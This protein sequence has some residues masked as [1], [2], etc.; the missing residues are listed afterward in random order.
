M[1]WM[2]RATWQAIVEFVG[3]ATD[4]SKRIGGTKRIRLNYQLLQEL[5]DQRAEMDGKMGIYGRKPI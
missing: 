5:L 3:E 2:A 4:Y 1:Q